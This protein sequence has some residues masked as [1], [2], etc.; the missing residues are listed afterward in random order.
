MAAFTQAHI[1]GV[2]PESTLGE[3]IA[4]SHAV[5]GRPLASACM[6]AYLP[7]PSPALLSRPPS[8][9]LFQSLV[10]QLCPATSPLSPGMGQVGTSGCSAGPWEPMSPLLCQPGGPR[11]PGPPLGGAAPRG[12]ER[13]PSLQ[14]PQPAFLHPPQALLFARSMAL[15]RPSRPSLP[16]RHCGPCLWLGLY[17]LSI[18][19][20][21]RVRQ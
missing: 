2:T 4:L 12:G 21:K 1:V 8:R 15:A 19:N 9:L 16:E 13:P 18:H 5:S 11:T 10:P 14:G 17:R 20:L 3:W 6:G 7:Q